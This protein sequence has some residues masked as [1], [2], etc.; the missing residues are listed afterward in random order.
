MQ[1]GLIVKPNLTEKDLTRLV[2]SAY[3]NGCAYISVTTP[4]NQS[5]RLTARVERT[6]GFNR[7]EIDTNS[8]NWNISE[9]GQIFFRKLAEDWPED[10]KNADCGKSI[11]RIYIKH[12]DEIMWGVGLWLRYMLKVLEK[13][14]NLEEVKLS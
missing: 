12:D 8:C 2:Q 4:H 10:T 14:E 6:K 3:K 1:Q 7:V 11:M 9:A 5:A 13:N